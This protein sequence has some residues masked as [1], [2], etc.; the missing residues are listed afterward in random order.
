MSRHAC[1]L[2]G[3]TCLSTVLEG[4]FLCSL[5]VGGF[6]GLSD[7]VPNSCWEAFSQQERAASSLW[8]VVGGRGQCLSQ[9]ILQFCVLLMLERC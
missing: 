9:N 8:V 1:Q 2:G 4:S 6:K 7:H 5:G 3:L